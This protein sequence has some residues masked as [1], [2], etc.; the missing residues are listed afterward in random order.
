MSGHLGKK[1]KVEVWKQSIQIWG[2]LDYCRHLF[3]IFYGFE[4]HELSFKCDYQAKFWNL[5]AGHLEKKKLKVEVLK[6]SIQIWGA[7]D[8][9]RHLFWSF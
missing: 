3:W 7:L 8:C 1:P 4:T 2:G 6:Q 5:M 9:C